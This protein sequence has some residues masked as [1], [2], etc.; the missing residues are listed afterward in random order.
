MTSIG[1]QVIGG[2]ATIF[3]SEYKPSFMVHPDYP[4]KNV[5]FRH[6]GAYSTYNHELFF[7]APML[8]ATHLS[9]NQHFE[10][11]QKWFH[12]IFNP[13]DSSSD[14]SPTR[15]WKFL[16]FYNNKH[17]EQEQIQALLTLLSTPN[18]KLDSKRETA[19]EGFRRPS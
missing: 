12:Y 11:A 9:Q 3:E 1:F 7:H 15:Y 14:P 16:P 4:E 19:E 10:E 6:E 18:M 2:L 13:T 5:D 8:V 17:P